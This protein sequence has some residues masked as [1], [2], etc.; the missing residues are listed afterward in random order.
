MELEEIHNSYLYW[1]TW[2]VVSTIAVA[3]SW[4]KYMWGVVAI[5]FLFNTLERITSCM[6]GHRNK[7][8]MGVAEIQSQLEMVFLS[9]STFECII[10][11]SGTHTTP[12]LHM[13]WPDRWPWNLNRYW[14]WSTHDNIQVNTDWNKRYSFIK[15]I[16]PSD[17]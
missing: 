5:L 12:Q 6:V 11:V 16:Y 3:I 8:R 2:N 10:S 7:C 4:I 9:H 1:S 14:I 17:I 15:N 13:S